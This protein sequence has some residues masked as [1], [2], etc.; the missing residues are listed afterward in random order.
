M[1]DDT[2]V[3][4]DGENLVMRYQEMLGGGL[5]PYADN[6]HINDSFIWNQRVLNDNLWNIKRISYYT[7]VVGDD[8]RVRGVR[9]R[10]ASVK[11]RC[12]L[13]GGTNDGVTR[14]AQLVPFVRKKHSKANKASICDMAIAVDVM[15]ACYRNHADAIWIF[16]GDGD[17]H[18]LVSEAVHAG[19]VVY[20]S[21]FSS[22]LNED[23]LH[24]VD[25]FISLDKHFFDIPTRLRLPP[26]AQASTTDEPHGKPPDLGSAPCA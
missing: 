7:S 20:L 19:K 1:I 23:L 24:A 18:Q 13:H 10:I 14:D 22:G 6:V 11:F 2:L 17:F 21:A 9:K 25:E 16:S 3:F 8:E 15:R 26:Q 4:V 5:A 12:R